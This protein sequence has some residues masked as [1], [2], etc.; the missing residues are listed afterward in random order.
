MVYWVSYA[1]FIAV[2]L[3]YTY[4]L[5]TLVLRLEKLETRTDLHA[6]TIKYGMRELRELNETLDNDLK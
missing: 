3:F 5:I 2:L 6:R 4:L 1:V